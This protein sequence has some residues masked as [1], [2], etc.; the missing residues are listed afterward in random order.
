[1]FATEEELGSD[2]TVVRVKVP[3][4][5]PGAPSGGDQYYYVYEVAD[6]DQVIHYRTIG[7]PL[8]DGRADRI[9]SR[10][11][12]VWLTRRIW[13]DEHKKLQRD[14]KG[15]VVVSEETYVLKDVWTYCES[16]LEKNIQDGIFSRLG[17]KAEIARR[18]FLTIVHDGVVTLCDGSPDVTAVCSEDGR[19]P[20]VW[21][22]DSHSHR[23]RSESKD[24]LQMSVASGSR[25]NRA[26]PGDFGR[27]ECKHRSRKHV[28]T[29][30]KECCRPVGELTSFKELF[31]CLIDIVEGQSLPHAKT[32]PV[33]TQR[34][35][36]ALN[37]MRLAGYVH[38]DVSTGNCL[39]HEGSG[40]LADLEYA[41]LQ[42]DIPQHE[43]ARVSRRPTQSLCS[44][45]YYVFNLQ[46]TMAFMAVECLRRKYL[47]RPRS[48]PGE[49]YRRENF[50]QHFLHD[51]ESVYWLYLW[52]VYSRVPRHALE[53]FKP[54]ATEPRTLSKA[55][56]NL[57][58]SWEQLFRVADTS[59]KRDLLD[60]TGAEAQQERFELLFIYG[61]ACGRLLEP[62]FFI[63]HLATEYARL[64]EHPRKGSDGRWRLEGFTGALHE[65]FQQ[66]LREA[67][68][69]LGDDDYSVVDVVTVMEGEGST[70]GSTRKRGASSVDEDEREAKRR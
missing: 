29:V 38:R 37:F 22:H 21:T 69:A 39:Y 14:D 49:A 5:E 16:R 13:L 35:M 45:T 43:P 59:R 66:D 23:S 4:S 51:L 52:F 10:A 42:K 62:I 28:R 26:E 24:E 56:D 48:A 15:N 11:T 53:D 67:L 64:Q 63:G 9:V 46:G 17:D 3:T 7:Q 40:K 50:A 20:G 27:T 70:A 61:E 47:F 65:R 25:W 34:W 19:T 33:L 8:S 57:I 18:Y 1:M 58:R 60:K 54:N 2:T 68:D 12:R 55:A 6:G 32:G 30:F 31:Q 44:L 41:K 36:E